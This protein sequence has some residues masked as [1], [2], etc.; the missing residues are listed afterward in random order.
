MSHLIAKIKPNKLEEF[1]K[2]DSANKSIY[3]S[4]GNK[5]KIKL[6]N[7][8]YLKV[9]PILLP[10]YGFSAEEVEIF[11]DVVPDRE[12]K[13][14]E[15]EVVY[16]GSKE[17]MDRYLNRLF[18]EKD[19]DFKFKVKCLSSLSGTLSW[20][21]KDH[22]EDF[23]LSH[24]GFTKNF[25]LTFDSIM[26]YLKH[27]AD[28]QAEADNKLKESRMNPKNIASQRYNG[29]TVQSIPL[30]LVVEKKVVVRDLEITKQNIQEVFKKISEMLED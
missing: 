24:E 1:L 12:C 28:K 23:L 14:F 17:L 15:F 7:S 3:H 19:L 6:A 2:R 4:L 9:S 25:S 10:Q 21:F 26:A 18:D 27:K 5:F 29:S 8:T 11:M 22:C 13:D 30:E 20:F 16:S